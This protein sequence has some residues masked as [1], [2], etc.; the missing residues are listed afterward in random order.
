MYLII[1][2]FVL[3]ELGTNKC[4][5]ILKI[6]LPAVSQKLKNVYRMT[7]YLQLSFASFNVYDS[8]GND[9][10]EFNPCTDFT[11]SSASGDCDT[12]TVSLKRDI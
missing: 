4:M 1:F 5:F 3:A 10:L 8:D 6:V 7:K 9:E 12:V 2:I 11:D